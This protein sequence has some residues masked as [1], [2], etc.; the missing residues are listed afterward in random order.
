MIYVPQIR[1]LIERTLDE[2]GA[3]YSTASS[4]N[5]IFGTG[6]VESKFKYILQHP[7]R[8]AKGFFQI[9]VPTCLDNIIN[10]ISFRDS[11]LPMLC[12]VTHVAEKYWIDP[13]AE[14]WGKILESNIRAGIVHARILYWRAP[15]KLPKELEDQAEYWV[16]YYNRGGKGTFLKYMEAWDDNEMVS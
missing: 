5:L 15:A 4:Q 11:M 2:M 12:D 14:D 3:K 9:E 6:L 10:Y 13:K 1:S 16:K 8:I 7:S